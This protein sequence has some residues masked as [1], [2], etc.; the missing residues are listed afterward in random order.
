LVTVDLSIRTFGKEETEPGLK[1]ADVRAPL[2]ASNLRV[3]PMVDP[4][5]FTDLSH[6]PNA[7]R[8]VTFAL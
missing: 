8:L 4:W 2:L 7:T 5:E 3:C 6:S 1:M